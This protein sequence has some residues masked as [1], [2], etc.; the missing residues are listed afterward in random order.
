[1]RG[2][3]GIRFQRSTV[4]LSRRVGIDVL[5]TTPANN[6]VHELMGGA[7]AVWDELLTPRT[8]IDLVDRLAFAH[9]ERPSD[10]AAQVDG[11]LD[12][13]VS[14]GVIQEVQEFDA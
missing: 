1:V 4:A 5:V 3:S 14:L 7:A 11:C 6:E 8:A 13:L 9:G 12:S 10:I 2:Q